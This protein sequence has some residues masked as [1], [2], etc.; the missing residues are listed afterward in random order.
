M[1]QMGFGAH[2]ECDY[3]NSDR[4]SSAFRFRDGPPAN[5][6]PCALG[7]AAAWDDDYA[8]DIG[9]WLAEEA[10]AKNVHVILG[11]TL[12]M[13][14]SPLGGRGFESFSEDPLLCGR[15]AGAYVRGMQA[16]GAA[17]TPKHFVCNDQEFERQSS[18]SEYPNI[19]RH[20]HN[21]LTLAGIVSIRALREIYLEPF[22]IMQKIGNPRAYMTGYN[23]LNGLHVSEHHWLLT[24]VL[25]EEWGFDGCVMSDWTGIYSTD[26]SIK[27]G[28]DLEMPGP[29]V[30]RGQQ[31]E[32]QLGCGKL[33]EYD[34]DPCVKSVSVVCH[35]IG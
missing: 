31:I 6:Y 13:Q 33:A 23:R 26:I 2:S 19:A 3:I 12:N 28:M 20:C 15:I 7:I 21:I 25:R 9:H 1:A 34:L 29:P 22:R 30:F 4:D 16:N 27:A 8:A 11:P 24:K 18:D 5:A 35:R 32:R 14:R 10:K 17:A